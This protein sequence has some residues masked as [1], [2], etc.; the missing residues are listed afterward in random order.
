MLRIIRTIQTNLKA[1]FFISFF[2]LGFFF[3]IP[4]TQAA[5]TSTLRGAAYW[6]AD[7]GY[8]YFNCK[9]DVMGDRL[10]I[11]LNNLSGSGKYAP[12]DDKFHFYAPPCFSSPHYVSIDSSSNLRGKA[13]NQVKGFISFEGT[14]TPPDG[15]G[16]VSS[17]CVSTCNASNNCWSCYKESNKRVYG[18]AQVDSTG[19]WIRLDTQ[20][21]LNLETCAAS[22]IILAAPS[23]AA[24]GLTPGDFFGYGTA[25]ALGN[26]YFN[27]KRDSSDPNCVARNYKVYVETLAVG[28]LTA[29]NFTYTQACGSNGLGA[30]LGWCVKSGQ[31]T[32]YEIVVN[33]YDGTSNSNFGPNPTPA[34]I[35]SAFCW[36]GVVGSSGADQFFPHL[37]CLNSLEYGANYYWWIRLYD[38]TGPTQWYQYFGNTSVD[39]D[40]DPDGVTG[41]NFNPDHAKTF[42]TFKHRFPTPFFTWSPFD[43]LVGTSTTFTAASS[44]FYMASQPTVAQSCSGSSCRYAWTTTDNQAIFTAI[45]TRDTDIIF[46]IATDTT[47][48]LALTDLDNYTCNMKSGLITINY[49]LPIWREIK[50]K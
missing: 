32:G 47:V 2:L 49:D 17:N 44:T 22:P 6:G 5:A 40:G 38:A 45:N 20:S 8:V 14:S 23:V 11:P 31:Q 21:T 26:L 29:P 3:F 9:D 48:S 46:K 39:T 41:P 7:K 28:A 12:P 36:T 25:G 15:Y 19:E 37:S 35:S 13:W 42:S 30:T 16:S 34:Q 33:K 1:S 18:W 10:D 43:I 24:T 4:N 50:A 27:C